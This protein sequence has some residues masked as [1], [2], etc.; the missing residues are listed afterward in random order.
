MVT[1]TSDM[2]RA[3]ERRIN[4][5]FVVNNLDVGGL[6][7]VVVSLLCNLYRDKFEPHLLRL[8]GAGKRAARLDLP[9]E[10]RL[11]LDRSHAIRL[12]VI[13]LSVDPF[14]LQRIRRFVHERKID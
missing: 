2:D 11:V 13:G 8:A 6:E 9:A 3:V 12:P 10:N 4:V 7:M 5:G 1:W 14:R